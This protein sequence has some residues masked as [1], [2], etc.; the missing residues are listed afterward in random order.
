MHHSSSD[1]VQIIQNPT[2]AYF[3]PCLVVEEC[4]PSPKLKKRKAPSFVSTLPR[5]RTRSTRSTG[6]I[7][8]WNHMEQEIPI[9]L[10]LSYVVKEVIVTQEP[11]PSNNMTVTQE[12]FSS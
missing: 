2:I 3:P 9:L 10:P 1:E 8:G 7:V 12:P 6:A 4:P 5:R 11:V